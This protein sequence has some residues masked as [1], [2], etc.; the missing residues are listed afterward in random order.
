MRRGR[1]DRGRSEIDVRAAHARVVGPP[2]REVVD[3]ASVIGGGRRNVPDTLDAASPSVTHVPNNKLPHPLG[4]PPWT[5]GRFA[6][7]LHAEKRRIIG[8][9]T[10]DGA[11]VYMTVAGSKEWQGMAGG[12][13][14]VLIPKF[15]YGRRPPWRS[16]YICAPKSSS[17]VCTKGACLL[18]PISHHPPLSLSPNPPILPKPLP[19][20]GLCLPVLSHRIVSSHQSS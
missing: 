20:G 8:D 17:C 18:L 14:G 3:D 5:A 2:P 10:R 15:V 19:L 6:P 1:E 4:S 11:F 7:L 16:T 13:L 9:E 12:C